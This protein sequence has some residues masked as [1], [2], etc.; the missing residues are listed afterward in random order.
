M[1]NK[2]NQNHNHHSHNNCGCTEVEEVTYIC[3]E[4]Q[5]EV[6]CDCKVK[7]LSTDCIIYTG[8]D[9]PCTEIKKNTILTEL[10]QQL[11]AFICKLK[12]DI[13]NLLVLVNIGT[14]AKVYAGNNLLGNKKLRTISKTGDLITVTEA[15][16]EIVIGLD[17][18]ELENTIINLTPNY[19]AEN[20]GTGADV[21]KEEVANTFRFRKLNLNSQT[22]EGVSVLRDFQENTND[23]TLRFKKIKS[24]SLNITETNEQIIIERNE[25]GEVP[26]LQVNNSY[27]PSYSEWLEENKIQNAGI[28]IAGFIFRGKGTTVQPF[29]DSTV[30]PLTGGSPTITPNT[31]IQNALDAYVGTGLGGDGINPA[32]RLNPKLQGQQIIVQHNNSSYTFGG[33]FNYNNI[34]IKLSGN[35]A[36]TTLGYLIDMDNSSYFNTINGRFL[37]TIDS[38]KVLQLTNSLGF[39]NSGN[40][41][42]T[43]PSYDSGR[44]GAIFG[45]GTLYSSY[46]GVDNLNR[47]IFKGDGNNNDDNLHFEIRC[48]VRADQQGIYFTKNKMRIDFYNRLQS[49]EFLGSGDVNLKAFHMTGGQVRFYE[50]G[51]IDCQNGTTGRLYAVTF[52]PED[53][54]IGYTIFQLN[55]SKVTGTAESFFAKL[56][57]EAVS[58]LAFNSPSGDG[59]AT[60]ILGTGTVTNGLFE[61]LGEDK[62]VIQFRNNVFSYTG[63]DQTK[64]DLTGGNQYSTINFI[65]DNVIENLVTRDNRALALSSLPLYSAYLKTNGTTYPNTSTWTRDIVLP[66]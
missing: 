21:Y 4:C 51:Q 61:N 35:V 36:A 65:G 59:F 58:F 5:P 52:E 63:I 48:K 40:T 37:I 33:D 8:D 39:R 34:N 16:E 29:T 41:S 47:Y 6:G 55:S 17:E 19:N 38:D 22:G 24:N 15:T 60:T 56:N 45:E 12:D 54:G 46:S 32:S 18:D 27:L 42:S 7:D 23:V 66:F 53:D 26:S 49:G 3:N 64:V 14:G 43:P 9:L 13:A 57:N 28:P 1:C 10:I 62:W 20:V 44:I 11:D 2:C 50:K 31:S 25:L 30:Y